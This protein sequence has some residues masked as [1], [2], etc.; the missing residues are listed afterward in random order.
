M[1]LR[2]RI[3]TRLGRAGVAAVLVALLVPALAGTAAAHAKHHKRAASHAEHHKSKHKARH[4][5]K[6][7]HRKHH[8][9]KRK[10]PYITKVR[11]MHAS[12]GDTLTIR[13]HNFR[14]GVN[15][16][17]VIFMRKGG[18]PVFVK[19][20][21]S[22]TKML[23]VTLPAALTDVL[24]TKS[25][26]PVATR[27]KLRILAKR[28][29]K[30]FT[31][32]KHSPV[33]RP[34]RAS[35]SP[36]TPGKPGTVP[37]PSPAAPQADC[38]GDGTANANDA[39]DDNDLLPDT[40]EASL[41]TDGCK[42]DTD[43]DGV[44]DGYEYQSAVD[45]NDDEYQNNSLGVVN[46]VLPYPGKRPYPNPLD[47]SDAATDYDGDSLQLGEEY[48]LW[49]YTIAHEGAAYSLKDLTYSDGKQYSLD[50]VD[51]QGRRQPKQHADDY[52][53]HQ[54]F[55]DWATANGYRNVFLYLRPADDWR[56]GLLSGRVVSIFDNN[57]DGTDDSSSYDI[58]GDGFISDD[59]RDED[60][61]G[62]TNFDETHGR[63]LPTW[64]TTCYAQEG[65]YPITYAGTSVVDPDTDG[66]G[67]RDG[68]DDQDHDDI[69]NIMELS[70]RVA[71]VSLTS[72]PPRPDGW[73]DGKGECKPPDPPKDVTPP[74]P[75][76][77]DDYGQ[78][79]PFNPCLPAPW[80]RTC[81]KHP[82]LQEQ[83]APFDLSP[84][85]YSLN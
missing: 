39:D 3:R 18:R 85:W 46:A 28:F 67:I 21:K 4:H 15:K 52:P 65:A 73:W 83:S 27:F 60:A 74:F 59:E 49:Q 8:K 68:A 72:V 44:S 66:D 55:V 35:D 23:R 31:S 53:K 84:D 24:K 22:T 7:K 43:G 70:R 77:Q 82:D 32:K 16:N 9:H 36:S 5:H 19:A 54:Q 20:A 78:V 57:L 33:I 58:D 1:E 26:V 6:A 14:R 13:G 63:M 45:L 11:P 12:I 64:W 10:L 75:L 48:K 41:K 80:S 2:A 79:N 56:N 37:A 69:P 40:L 34:A 47:P 25:G 38:D 17:T 51:A 62:L 71:S 61:D 50:D 81:A 29:G 76:H 30:S 42:A